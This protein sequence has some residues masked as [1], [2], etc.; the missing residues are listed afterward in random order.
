MFVFIMSVIILT[1][2]ILLGVIFWFFNERKPEKR[3]PNWVSALFGFLAG[4]VIGYGCVLLVNAYF[5]ARS[6]I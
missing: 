4:L 1:P 6:M 2:A 5:I 3:T